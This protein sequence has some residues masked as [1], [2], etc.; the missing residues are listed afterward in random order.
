MATYLIDGVKYKS[1]VPLS[2]EELEELASQG[3]DDKPSVYAEAARKGAARFVSPIIGAVKGAWTGTGQTG[4]RQYA[5]EAKK[6]IVGMLG[7]TGA[8]PETQLQRILAG[9]VEA[10]ADPTSYIMPGGSLATKATPILAPIA[11]GIESFFAGSGAEAGGYAGGKAGGMLGGETGEKVGR[12]VGALGGGMTGNVVAGTLPRTASLVVPAVNKTRS[13]ISRF[14]GKEPIELAEKTALSHIDNI[15]VEAAKADPKFVEVFE[16]ALAAQARTGIK[17]PLSSLMKDNAVINAYI[18][19][20]ASKH[21]SFREE[22]SKQF[23]AVKSGLGGKSSALFGDAKNADEFILKAMSGQTDDLAQQAKAVSRKAA[24]IDAQARK[25]AEDVDKVNP[26]EFG[27]RITQSV[28]AAEESARAATRPLYGKAFEIAKEKNLSLPENAVDDIYN[29]VVSGKNADV[30]ATFPTIYQKVKNAF[31]PKVE[32]GSGIVD[33]FGKPLTQDVQKFSAATVEDLD[34]LKREINRQLRG[35]RTDSHIRVLHDLKDKVSQHIDELDPD[36]VA[37]YRGADQAYLMKVGLPFNEETIK[38]IERA[39]FNENIVPLL[40]KNKSTTGQFL[41]TTGEHGKK[42]VED[43]F[44]NE[45]SKFVKDGAIDVAKANAWLASKRE[46]LAL[47]PDVKAR[48]TYMVKNT[49]KLLE[50]KNAIESAFDDATKARILNSEGMSAQSLVGKMYS[51]P[52]YTAKF[53]KQ[54]GNDPDAIRAV[55]SFMLDD[56]I[57]NGKPLD[58]LND[59]SRGAIYDAVF[60]KTYKSVISDLALISD[61]VTKDPSAVVA[62]IKGLDADVL[63][64]MVGMKPERLTSLFFTN[65]VVSKPVAVMT[66]LNRFMNK[67]AG[68][69]AEKK[70]ME[71]LLDKEAGPRMLLAIKQSLK[72][73]N[74]LN[75]EKYATWAKGKGYDFVDMLKQDVRGGT[76]RSTGGMDETPINMEW[77]DEQP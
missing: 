73:K 71:M 10:A 70:M 58:L 28:E 48:L 46:A 77:M 42:L 45:M 15:F 33:E 3:G 13:L 23:D 53:M 19:H 65:P 51:A 67:Q 49:G 59:K 61:R 68:D 63:T 52:Q 5:E 41:S 38:T 6:S 62:N 30:F 29:T 14:R 18:G 54:Y 17:M 7:G 66:V 56:I 64:N 25:I 2:D 75:L 31:V 34:S 26:Y 72:E 22:F 8:E 20:L 12:V 21:A 9:G 24:G 69:I 1:D 35:A 55:R 44:V 37:A 43:A 16:E 74:S 27:S 39:K 60:G 40:T 11:K 47:V 32:K 36:F 76:L 57:K 50:R 4:A